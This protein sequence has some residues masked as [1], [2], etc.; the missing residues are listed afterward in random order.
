MM[1]PL[2]GIS[3]VVA[4]ALLVL[5]AVAV[6]VLLYTW[7]SGTVS[8]APTSDVRL[9]ERITIDSVYVCNDTT[10]KTL[11]FTIY[12]RNIG[13]RGVNVSSAY[14]IDA[15]TG[16]LINATSANLVLAKGAVGSIVI[17][18]V[19][20]STVTKTVIVKAVTVNGVS[21]SYIMTVPAKPEACS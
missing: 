18:K 19:P 13:D 12:V 6:S 16:A 5:I 10:T 21:A 14:I 20:N 1:K 17:S 3:P 11:K 15:D 2:R 7:V 9:Q 4:T 8:T